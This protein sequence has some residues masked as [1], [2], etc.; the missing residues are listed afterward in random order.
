MPINLPIPQSIE[1]ALYNLIA[2]ILRRALDATVTLAKVLGLQVSGN[3]TVTGTSTLTGNVAASGT[4]AVT[5]ASTLTGGATVGA[6]GVTFNDATVQT[7]AASAIP[8]AWISFTPAMSGFG[9]MT[10][11]AGTVASAYYQIIG[12]TMF[13]NVYIYN[14][15]L[16][17]TASTDIYMTLPASKMFSTETF[18]D[19]AAIMDNSVWTTGRK[20]STGSGLTKVGWN[21]VNSGNWTLGTDVARVTFVGCFGIQ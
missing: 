14:I 5:G 9:S 4:L 3:L 7:T 21:L 17:G 1:P 11:S 8:G 12:K 6:A 18:A 13:L 19:A 10:V 16:G 20:F 15:T 2:E